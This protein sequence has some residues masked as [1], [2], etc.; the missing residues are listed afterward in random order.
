MVCTPAPNM[1]SKMPSNP[2][3]DTPSHL[4]ARSSKGEICYGLC[5]GPCS[6]MR[7]STRKGCGPTCLPCWWKGGK[8]I[9]DAWKALLISKSD[10]LCVPSW[11]GEGRMGLFWIGTECYRLRMD[12]LAQ[13]VW[14]LPKLFFQLEIGEEESHPEFT[15]RISAW[16]LSNNNCP[17]PLR[18][19]EK[20]IRMAKTVQRHWILSL[21][22]LFCGKVQFISFSL[23]LWMTNSVALS[24]HNV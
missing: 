15:V 2:K 11:A 6:Y 8:N 22:R 20:G 9:I 23:I 17:S 3:P 21:F 5:N 16:V 4:L 18:S 24:R 1:V 7:L 12:L 13:S 10:V 19:Q 14:V